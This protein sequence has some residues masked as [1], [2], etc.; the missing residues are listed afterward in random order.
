MAPQALAAAEMLSE[1]EGVEAT[2]LCLSSPDRLY[3]DWRRTQ[4]EPLRNRP[5]V[6][7]SSHLEQLLTPDEVGVSVVTVLDG[8]SHALAWIGS[9]LG[10]R[11]VPLG[12]DAF[13]QAGSQPAV[14]E[15]YDLAPNAIVAAALSAL[16]PGG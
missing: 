16:D 14:Y 6:E 15:A 12:V 3:R 2:V 9:A 7:R 13:G 8:A 11:C 5:R 10:V 1:E 4:L